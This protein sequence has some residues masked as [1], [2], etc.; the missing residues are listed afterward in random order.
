MTPDEESELLRRYRVLAEIARV[1][2]PEVTIVLVSQPL[3]G[4]DGGPTPLGI[5]W[6]MTAHGKEWEAGV[7]YPLNCDFV[8]LVERAE[9]S[10]EM[11]R[12]EGRHIQK[13]GV[14]L[15]PFSGSFTELVAKVDA[16]IAAGVPL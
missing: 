6:E 5:R 8:E 10:V 16:A 15:P 11:W 14:G 1:R 3:A 13:F 7:D 2:W 4:G 9:G 12:L